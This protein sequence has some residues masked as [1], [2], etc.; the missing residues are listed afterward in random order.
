M[1]VLGRAGDRGAVRARDRVAGAGPAARDRAMSEIEGW[2][3][4]AQARRLR[5]VRCAGLGHGR[6]DRVVPRAL[7]GRAGAR[8]GVRRRDRSARAAAIAGRRRSRPTRPR[9]R[10]GSRGVSRQPRGGRRR[11][12]RPP[13]AQTVVGGARATSPARSRCCSSTARIASGRRAATSRDWGARVAP[14]GTMLVHDAFSSIGVTA[15]L[16]TVCAGSRDVAISG[17]TG[18]LAEYERRESP[19][20]YPERARDIASAPRGGAVVR[21]QRGDQGARAGRAAAVGGAARARP[22]RAMAL[23]SARIISVIPA[24]AT[25]W[26]AIR[27]IA[28]SGL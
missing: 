12:A 18:S 14:G 28:Y 15:A 27:S 10:R 17:R 22:G 16:F 25:Q 23:L 19:G 21:A 3:T 24:T 6:R 8:R 20:S 4:E 7:D 26:T 9:R 1:I 11:G 13:R 2:L 5:G